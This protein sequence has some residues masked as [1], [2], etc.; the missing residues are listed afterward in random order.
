MSY[1]YTRNA[2]KG[3]EITSESKTI[4]G[5]QL[6]QEMGMVGPGALMMLV[7]KWNR[8]GLIGVPNGGPVYVYVMD[9]T[10]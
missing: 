6:Y 7:N 2:I 8:L 10:I 9:E 1:R 5:E 4:T 3:T